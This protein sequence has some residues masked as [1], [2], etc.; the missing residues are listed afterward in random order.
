MAVRSE[1]TEAGLIARVRHMMG[2][3]VGRPYPHIDAAIEDGIRSGLG[4]ALE[5]RNHALRK[6][7]REDG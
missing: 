1:V 4:K 7:D 6:L 2:V 3:P 5:L